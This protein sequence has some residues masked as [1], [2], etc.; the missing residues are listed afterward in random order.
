[1]CPMLRECGP[2]LGSTEPCPHTADRSTRWAEWLL[3]SQGLGL[4]EAVPGLVPF[5]CKVRERVRGL[6]VTS[7]DGGMQP[8]SQ[9]AAP[10]GRTSCSL[11]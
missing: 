8:H 7:R 4:V 3:L 5:I 9:A 6:E 11:C 1:M 2:P 10:A